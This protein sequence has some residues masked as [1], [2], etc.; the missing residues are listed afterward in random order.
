MT[1]AY[2]LVGAN[3]EPGKN[4]KEILEINGLKF[5]IDDQVVA[6]KTEFGGFCSENKYCPKAYEVRIDECKI[7]MRH[8]DIIPGFRYC[9]GNIFIKTIGGEALIDKIKITSP[10][11]PGN[12]YIRYRK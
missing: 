11:C 3:N 6:I 9:T 5:R 2:G 8:C 7:L 12:I 4:L 10:D 1:K